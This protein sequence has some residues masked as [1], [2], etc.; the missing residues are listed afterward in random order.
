MENQEKP[1]R[2]RK[3]KPNSRTTSANWK[4]SQASIDIAKKMVLD[5]VT[6]LEIERN[7][8]VNSTRVKEYPSDFIDWLFL[9]KTNELTVMCQVW[10]Q[11]VETSKLE[12]LPHY[13]KMAVLKTE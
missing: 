12:D 9:N 8:I 7:E 3:K 13:R 6:N 5:T 1:K 11:T 2:N 4:Y 10:A